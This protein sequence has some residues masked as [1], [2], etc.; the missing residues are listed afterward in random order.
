MT[1]PGISVG[2]W[3]TVLLVSKAQTI[4]VMA[5]LLVDQRAEPAGV[6]GDWYGI[7]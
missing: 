1:K 2:I 5:L 4:N 3:A 6:C 7:A